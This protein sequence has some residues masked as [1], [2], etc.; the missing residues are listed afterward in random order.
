MDLCGDIQENIFVNCL[1]QMYSE[2][3]FIF[4]VYQSVLVQ[5]DRGNSPIWLYNFGYRGQ[6]SYGD[7][8]AITTDDINFKWGKLRTGSETTF[9]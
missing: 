6:H 1:L 8:F 3:A 5:A 9:Y 7:Y 2:R 4:G